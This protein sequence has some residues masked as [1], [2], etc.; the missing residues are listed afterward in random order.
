MQY[1]VNLIADRE[2]PMIDAGLARVDELLGDAELVAIVNL[3]ISTCCRELRKRQELDSGRDS[4]LIAYT[5]PKKGTT[6]IP[7]RSRF[8]AFCC[9]TLLL[10]PLRGA[11]QRPK[12]KPKRLCMPLATCEA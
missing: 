4:R 8:F 5:A 6:L 7:T 9:L 10:A 1:L 3:R 2:A 11:Q 12:R